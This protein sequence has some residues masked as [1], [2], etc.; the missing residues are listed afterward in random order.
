MGTLALKQ[1]NVNEPPAAV[2]TIGLTGSECASDQQAL[3]F[4]ILT[5]M[6]AE[7][8][9][10][11]VA[12]SHY[13]CDLLGGEYL[14]LTAMPDAGA[15][16]RAQG[17]L[18]LYAEP[19]QSLLNRLVTGPAVDEVL[20]RLATNVVVI[21]Q[22]H[23]PLQNILLILRLDALD[24][25][26]V[27]WAGRLAQRSGAA[28]TVLPLVPTPPLAYDHLPGLKAGVDSL[29]TTDT[30]AGHQLRALLG[31]LVARQVESTVHVRPGAPENQIRWEAAERA[32]DLIVVG[33]EP[34]S[35][36]RRWLVG[37]VVGPLLSWLDRPLLVAKTA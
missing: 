9:P 22:P 15:G 5:L 26:A 37:N 10:A 28:V 19:E 20:H 13:L 21:R 32:Y 16:L 14:D 3:A 11:A 36:W 2:R 6:P 7:Q 8:P 25:P 24:E 17:D 33:M 23:Y 29:L 35:H 12:F 27:R 31:Q 34:E 30:P 1:P 18:V 4:R